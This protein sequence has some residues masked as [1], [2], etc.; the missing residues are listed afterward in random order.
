MV[1]PDNGIRRRV[2]F[3]TLG[4]KLNQAETESIATGFRTLNW[5]VADFGGEADVVVINSCT[6]T[7]TADRKSRAA[8]NQA[9]RM[10][11]QGGI[12]SGGSAGIL[13]HSPKSPLW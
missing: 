13:N 7:N 12:G 6:V 3:K 10:I 1:V 2:A 11:G 9:L 8:M 5:E 4:C